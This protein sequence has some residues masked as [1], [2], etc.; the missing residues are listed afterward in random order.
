MRMLRVLTLV[1]LVLVVILI[2]GKGPKQRAPHYNAETEVR[3][4][5]V[6]QEVREYWCP[7]NSDQG[8]HLMLKTDAGIPE[9]HVAPVRFLQ[10]NNISFGK[11]DQI[12][13]IGSA[14]VYQGQN[15][16]IVRQITRGDQ[17]FAFRQSDGRP[18]WVEPRRAYVK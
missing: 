14:V 9:L 3:A 10:G 7:I 13:A 2:F 15:A 8:T 16:L 1:A 11:G 6:I 17:T 12:A 18:L 5:G 4:E